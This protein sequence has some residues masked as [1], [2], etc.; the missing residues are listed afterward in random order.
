MKT[1][2]GRMSGN[3][4]FRRGSEEAWLPAYCYIKED[5]G[6]L[7]SESPMDGGVHKTLVPDLR[8][9]NVRC[10]M[11]DTTQ[12]SY[13]E[14]ALPTNNREVQLRVS[15]KSDLDAWFAALL[16]WQ[17]IQPK[18]LHNRKAKPQSAHLS[19]RGTDPDSRQ[20]PETTAQKEAPVIKVGRMIFWDTDISFPT[21]SIP[22]TT[23]GRPAFHRMHSSRERTYGS[24]W[25]RRVSCTLRENGELK[26][27][28][29]AENNLVSV[30][31]LSQL[32]RSA[33]Q[34][35]DSSL[36]ES[37]FCMAV[38][39]QYTANISTTG[40]VRPIYLSFESRVL[41]E[42]WFVLLRAFTIPQLYGPSLPVLE[43]KEGE[44]EDS[45]QQLLARARTD[46]FR[47]ERTLALK[48][49]EAKL[50]D[51]ST[52]SSPNPSSTPVPEGSPRLDSHSGLYVEV[53]LDGEPRSKT[54]IKQGSSPF[55]A[56]DFEFLDLP[57]VLT[58]ASVVLK[59]H[60]MDPA[61]IRQELRLV[62]E[63]YGLVQTPQDSGASSG[64]AGISHDQTLGKV[65]IILEELEARKDMEQRWPVLDTYGQR[66]GEILIRAR[67][68]ENV[69]LMR[70]EYEPLA[71]LL[72]DFT[73]NLT[74]QIALAI[75]TELKRL[76]DCLLNI[77]QV[78]GLVADWLMALVEDEIDGLSKETPLS[79]I[80][81]ARMGSGEADNQRDKVV[82][83]MN[84]NAAL[85]ANLLFR[86]NTLLTKA[87]DTHM[88]RV[89]GD[90]LA[91]AVGSAILKINER[92]PECEVDTNRVTNEH[93]MRRN[94]YRLVQTTEEVWKAISS[95][96]QK[97][98]I[99]LRLIFRHIKACAEDRYG[100]FLRSVSYSSVSGFLFLRFFVPAILNPRLFGLLKGTSYSSNFRVNADIRVEEPKPRAKRTLTL[101]AK[102][103]QTLA[104]MA[105]FGTKEP[106]MEPMNSFLTQHRES[107]KKFIEDICFVP[108]STSNIA[109]IPP[110]Y[111]TP[112]AIKNR[113][114]ITSKEG[115]PSLPYLIDDSREYA[116][117]VDL[118][119][120][121]SSSGKAAATE[122]DTEAV[123]YTHLTLPT[124]YSV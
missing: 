33:I 92:D 42:V 73:N 55:W 44:S 64:Y 109:V 25:W 104:N 124:I 67:A 114:P 5:V 113:L 17:P 83:D 23:S 123:S 99:E 48:I 45:Y 22:R 88:R 34:R 28:T 35:L 90:Y 27:F 117:L 49:I 20:P 94:W 46:M 102:S 79:R 10:A 21:T 93:E 2:C 82:R 70:Q 7:M 107:F 9:C 19:A 15:S 119:L 98:P 122:E 30:V 18:G 74:V 100:D 110:S 86:G 29:E 115:F 61:A 14:I 97:C 95:T 26:L 120:Q 76:S 89:G 71:R 91:L 101:V 12:S 118:W 3:V 53:H 108:Q 41:Y 57:A 4:V 8:G 66:I 51:D 38:Y 54:S 16:C 84:K 77:F 24:R 96:A 40:A 68:E 111:S 112:N 65:E 87:L 50:Q 43:I 31:Q 81:Y 47:M 69:I 11:D 121:G 78:Q 103:L 116:N 58:S 52:K 59:N 39:P 72:Q 75:P 13:I 1:L 56:Q 62:T 63:A 37:E 106:W 32:S 85:E 105:T 80:R 6:S 36:L 60:P